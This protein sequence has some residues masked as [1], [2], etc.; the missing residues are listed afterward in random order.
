I[1]VVVV[2][3]LSLSHSCF[4][5]IQQQN[6]EFPTILAFGDSI[7]DTDNNNLLVTMTRSNFVPYGRD[8]PLHIPTGRFGN[9]KVLSDLVASSLGIKDLLPAFRS[10]FL[11]ASELPTGVCFASGGSGLDKL[12][13]TILVRGYMGRRSIGDAAKVKE[14]I[15]NAVILISVGNND[16][17]VTYYATMARRTSYNIETYTDMLIGWK[18]VFIKN[19]YNL[20]VRKFAV[21]G[22]IP[23]GC[24]P[25]ARQVNEDFTC[26]PTVNYAARIYNQKVSTMVDKFSQNLPDAKLVHIDLYNPLIHVV[27]NPKQY[28]FTTAKPCCCSVMSPIPCLNSSNHVFW[29]FGHPSEKAIRTVLPSV[30]NA[31][32]NKLA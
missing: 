14:I 11:K 24:L 1:K 3:L 6:R 17:A 32:R 4:Q 5:A 22:T 16:I 9:G 19:L 13:A 8:F 23:I 18:T 10:P 29:D 15:A 25:G 20:G 2:F 26:N 27:N 28:G 12:T 21:L 30:V 7:L 31:I